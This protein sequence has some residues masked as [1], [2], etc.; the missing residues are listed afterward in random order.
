MPMLFAASMIMV[1][2]GTV[3]ERPSMARVTLEVFC[4]VAASDIIVCLLIEMGNGPMKYV[5]HIHGES[6]ESC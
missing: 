6:A 2:S 4:V 1:P 3:S 5:A